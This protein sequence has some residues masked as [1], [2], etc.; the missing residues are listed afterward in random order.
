MNMHWWLSGLRRE[1]AKLVYRRFESGPVL[2]SV[3]VRSLG[4]VCPNLSRW[5]GR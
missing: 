5:S 4:V 2:I 1:S 3:E